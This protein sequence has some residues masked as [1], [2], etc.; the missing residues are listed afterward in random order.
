MKHPSSSFYVSITDGRVRK[1]DIDDYTA[2]YTPTDAAKI[3]VQT[4]L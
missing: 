3:Q 4:N 2:R 1:H